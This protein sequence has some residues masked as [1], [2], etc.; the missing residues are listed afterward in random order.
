[1]L[2]PKTENQETPQERKAQH[3]PE[4]VIPFGSSKDGVVKIVLEFRKQFDPILRLVPSKEAEEFLAEQIWQRL[5]NGRRKL[6][7]LLDCMSGIPAGVESPFY[8]VQAVV[9]QKLAVIVC[10]PNPRRLSRRSLQRSGEIQQLWPLWAAGLTREIR[11]TFNPESR[12]KEASKYLEEIQQELLKHFKLRLLWVLAK[13]ESDEKNRKAGQITDWHMHGIVW[14]VEGEGVHRTTFARRVNRLKKFIRPAREK[15]KVASWRTEAI[16]DLAQYANYLSENQDWTRTYRKSGEDTAKKVKLFSSPKF[17]SEHKGKCVLWEELKTPE[18]PSEFWQLYHAEKRKI[19][20]ARGRDPDDPTQ[21][22][23]RGEGAKIY[24]K[25]KGMPRTDLP[26]KAVIR[27]RDGYRYRVVGLTNLYPDEPIYFYLVRI[28]PGTEMD[29]ACFECT[30]PQL[31][32]L[33]RDNLTSHCPVREGVDP[34][35]GAVFANRPINLVRT[36]IRTKLRNQVEYE[37]WQL[38]HPGWPKS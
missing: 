32:A 29:G 36:A 2:T 18:R 11:I 21:K 1:M 6:A 9:F 5:P 30:L 27:V 31:A 37:H 38:K 19:L 13:H 12:P 22:L 26:R 24:Q 20:L 10:G 16:R 14:P 34:V 15:W 17:L 35:S 23:T 28:A 3:G 8:Q 25:L 33:A 7:Y 4:L